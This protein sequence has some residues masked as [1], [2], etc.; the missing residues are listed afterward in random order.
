MT[1]DQPNHSQ[2]AAETV[3]K[4]AE[5]LEA[6]GDSV[7][8][9]DSLVKA[10]AHLHRW[11]DEATGVVIIPALGRVTIL[12]DGVVSTIQSPDLPMTMSDPVSGAPAR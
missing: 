8:G 11:V 10:R 7:F 4:L 6:T 3:L 5:E 9:G 12:H 2:S 1:E